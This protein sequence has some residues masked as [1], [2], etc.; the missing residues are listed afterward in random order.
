MAIGQEVP[1]ACEVCFQSLRGI[2]GV[3][4]RETSVMS[5]T[6]LNRIVVKIV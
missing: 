1:S 4:F 3:D 6:L 5:T 2:C